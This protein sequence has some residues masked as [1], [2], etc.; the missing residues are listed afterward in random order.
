MALIPPF[1]MDCV[2]AI[3]AQ[4]KDEKVDWFATGFLYGYYIEPGPKEGMK[5]Y[6]S[7]LVSNRHVF[8]GL[9]EIK[10]RCNPKSGE[11]AQSISLRLV[12]D[13]GSL[14]WLT[15]PDP[16]IDV[17]VVA[18]NVQQLMDSG[19]QVK[20]FQGDEHAAPVEKLVEI[21]TSEGD[22]VYVLGFP[23]GI[24]G[25]ARNVVIV[26]GGTIARIRD[27]LED[28]SR[29]FLVDAAIFPGNSGGPVVSK[30]E[31]VA[32]E[33]TK[34]QDRAYLIGIVRS[35][36][37]YRDVAIS[38]QTGLPRVVFEENSNLAEVHPVDCI[39]E[40]IREHLATLGT[41]EAAPEDDAEGAQETKGEEE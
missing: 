19:L 35:Y 39:E 30:P 22:F 24:V 5:R 15:S 12:N 41:A 1:V 14:R 34:E 40:A 37:P 3:G 26:R 20:V 13:D 11:P 4:K 18:L 29:T 8:D 32:I 33:G 21:G 7:Y 16:E 23:M 10:M 17:A 2:V 27:T 9:Q 28:A 31:N 25:G 36:V 38:T 6:R